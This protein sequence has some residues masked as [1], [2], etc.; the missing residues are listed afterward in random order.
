MS[1]TVTY[2]DPSERGTRREADA[3]ET[4]PRDRDQ[5]H[6]KLVRWFEEAERASVDARDMAEKCRDYLS[7]QQWTAEEQ[8]ILRLRNQPLLSINYIRR[9]VDLLCGLERK[10][11]TDPKAFPRTPTEDERADAA[12]QALRYV[13]DD[14]NFPVV[15]SS[16]YENMLV[17]GVGGCEVSI[18]DDGKGGADIT[19]EHVGYER[20]WYDPHSRAGDFHDARYKGLV[21]WMDRDQIEEL[22][23]DAGDVIG[24]SA[25]AG[26]PGSYDDRPNGFV[27]TDTNR[28]RTRI[29]ACHWQEGDDWWEATYSRAGFLVDPAKSK[30]RDR[31][32]N[33]ACRLLLQSAYIDREN[34]RYGMVRDLIS[35]QDELNKRRSKALHLLSVHQVIAEKGAVEDIDKARREIARPDGLVEVMP[36]LRFEVLPSGDLAQGQFHLLQHATGEMQASGP[37]ASMAGT[38]PRELSGRAILAQQ[39]GGAAQNEPLADALRMLSRRVYEMWWQAAREFWSPGKW[40]RVTDDLGAT[41]WVGITRPVTVRDALAEMPEQQRSVAMQRMQLVPGDPRLEQVIR[42]ENDITD[43][44]VDV[45]IEEGIDVPAI[46]AEQFQTLVQLAGMQPGL[47]PGDVLIAASGLKNKDQLLERMKAHAEQQAQQQQ[48]QAPMIEAHAQADLAG[49]QAKA[50]ADAALAKERNIASV[51]ALHSM[52]GDFTAP[53]YG[54]SHVAPPPD[55]PSAPG[56]VVPPATMMAA[57]ASGGLVTRTLSRTPPAEATPWNMLLPPNTLGYDPA[58]NDPNARVIADPNA[59][60]DEIA[61]RYMQGGEDIGIPPQDWA[62]PPRSHAAGGPIT[63]MGGGDPPGPD[64]GFITAKEGEYVLNRGAV[65]RYGPELLDAI[66]RGLIDPKM[67]QVAAAHADAD[68]RAKHR[69]ADVHEATVL[70]KLAQ[71]HAVMNPPPPKGPANG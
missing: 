21:V 35:L 39:A 8:K 13:A 1:A 62:G 65:A 52:R 59:T 5:L 7:G 41:R 63:T 18:K 38:D 14:T 19:T 56:T 29:L 6:A 37:N 40:V 64:D 43:L 22:Y 10:A 16:M 30:F 67:L 36:G 42:V 20:I 3:P 15:R 4:Y 71:A 55:A 51:S 23:P 66:N 27:W 25:S 34:R 24:D 61:M 48:R 57:H 12:T 28:Q 32:G 46:Q 54:E 2:L 69:Q 33:S 70:H 47:I 44:D 50:A 60:R 49:K 68:L 11:R 17:E 9:K 58:L 45:T 53:P 26:G 31:S